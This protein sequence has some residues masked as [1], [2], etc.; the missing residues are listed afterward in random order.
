VLQVDISE[1]QQIAVVAAQ[2]R[3]DSS[4]AGDLG[5]ALQ[6]VI[7]EG[8]TRIVLDVGGVDYMSSAGLR[9]IVLALKQVRKDNGD[10]RMAQVSE[11]VYE[12]LELSG[13]NTIVQIFDSQAD[14]VGSF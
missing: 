5:T 10:M 12:V 3:I 7:D 6:Q 14:A 2:G 4:T 1:N 11:R 8:H 9:E 13:L